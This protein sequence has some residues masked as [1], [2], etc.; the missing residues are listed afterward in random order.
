M[1][2]LASSVRP[3]PPYAQC[4]ALPA[5]QC[6]HAPTANTGGARAYD[7]HIYTQ[8]DAEI[9]A[10][11]EELEKQLEKQLRHRDAAENMLKLKTKKSE[12]VRCLA[13]LFGP[14]WDEAAGG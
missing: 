9:A 10:K 2:P 3:P 1:A 5:A 13:W 7:E 4:F 14:A 11:I 12:R 8:T 6:D